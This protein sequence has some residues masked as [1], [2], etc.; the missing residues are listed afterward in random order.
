MCSLPSQESASAGRAADAG[1][2]DAKLDQN[3]KPL[4]TR[5]GTLRGCGRTLWAIVR[6]RCPRCRQG[7]MFRGLFTMNDPCPVCGL[8][9]ERDEGYFLGA[10]YVSYG[11]S[12][13]LLVPAYL[14]ATA[15][16]P[17]LNTILIALFLWVPYL[18][19]VPVVFRYSRVIWINFDRHFW[20]ED[21]HP[22]AYQLYRQQQ[23]AE[24]QRRS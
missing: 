23:A 21:S 13:A 3:A 15:L 12:C 8:L 6:Q 7:R 24:Q 11:L 18:P 17:R 22:T 1:A 20:P 9:F 5:E 2:P 14:A 16:M 10:M 19:F 4:A